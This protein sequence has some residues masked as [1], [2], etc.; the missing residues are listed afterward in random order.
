[1]SQV[2][3][4][5]IYIPTPG[6]HYSAITGSAI[7]TLIYE[8]TRKHIQAGGRSQIVVGRNTQ[9]DY[10]AGEHVL[11]DF[12]PLPSRARKIADVAMGWLGLPRSFINGSYAPA[13]RAIDP[14]FQG[15]VFIQNT[16]GPAAQFKKHSP[17]AHVCI[18]VHNELF[19]TYGAGELR[20]TVAA[21]DLII[22]NCHF[23]ADQLLERMREGRE[24]VRVVHNGVDTERFVP[25][26]ELVSREEVSILFVARMVPAKGAHL[27][28]K[29]AAKLHAGGKRFKLRIVGNQG[30]SPHDP[31]SPYEVQLRQTAAPMGDAV[32]FLPFMDRHKIL[33]VYQAASIFCAPSNYNEPCTLTVPES[34]ACGR[35][36]IASRRGGI[37]EIG[38]DAILYFDPP[39]TDELADRLA[40]LIDS[41]SLREEWGRRARARAQEVDWTV[42]YQAQ[43]QALGG[44]RIESTK[45]HAGE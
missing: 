24:K 4:H 36:V 45:V 12:G 40:D 26:P 30:F 33:P 35:P 27:L 18:N 25:R 31:L 38:K 3:N 29:A 16:P 22:C 9:H 17:Q 11:V 19:N 20:R 37:P 10:P 42:Q 44:N 13:V 1:M 7:M 43:R 15:T 2:L 28:I 8:F 32:E 41:E 14:A 5:H 34:M 39:D 21:T 23:L 6:D